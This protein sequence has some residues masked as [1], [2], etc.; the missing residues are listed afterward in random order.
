M[1]RRDFDQNKSPFL[2]SEEFVD[3]I[4]SWERESFW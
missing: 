1:W 4:Q 3:W 2:V